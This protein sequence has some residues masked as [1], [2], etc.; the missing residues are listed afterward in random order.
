LQ[1][2]LIVARY[3]LKLNVKRHKGKARDIYLIDGK[4]SLLGT[5]ALLAEK[6][7]ITS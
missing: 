3:K 1:D 4:R 6:I 7:S 5:E 2:Y